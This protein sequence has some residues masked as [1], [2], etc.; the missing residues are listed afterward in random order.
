MIAHL[1]SLLLAILPKGTVR[2][3][4]T[5]FILVSILVGLVVAAYIMRRRR[6]RQTQ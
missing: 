2:D 4:N 1:S 3:E 6:N 5:F